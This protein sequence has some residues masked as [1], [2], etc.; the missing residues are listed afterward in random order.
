MTTIEAAMQD[1]FVYSFPLNE[2]ASTRYV[3]TQS[4]LNVNHH[5]VGSLVHQRA[6]NYHN[7]RQV[8]PPNNDTFYSSAWLDLANGH[9]ELSLPRIERID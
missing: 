6:L 8:T 7:S 3:A 4:P 5:P 1:A 9:V 2:V